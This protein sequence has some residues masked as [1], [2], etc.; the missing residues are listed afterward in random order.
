LKDD[1]RD[2]AAGL[3]CGIGLDYTELQEQDTIECFEMLEVTA[4]L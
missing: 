1:M 4:A 2:V 3:E